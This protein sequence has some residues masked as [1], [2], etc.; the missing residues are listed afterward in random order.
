MRELF[1]SKLIISG[2]KQNI[3]LY[4]KEN[5]TSDFYILIFVLK[6]FIFTGV[7]LSNPAKADMVVRI[8][9]L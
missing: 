3:L 4:L 9:I 7:L 6:Y 1:T 5:K 2:I 8:S